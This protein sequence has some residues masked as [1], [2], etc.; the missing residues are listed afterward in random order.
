M[1]FQLPA[2][3]FPEAGRIVGM[4]DYEHALPFLTT[5]SLRF[6]YGN[7][8]TSSAHR[9]ERHIARL[10]AP[11]MIAAL[12]QAGFAALWIDRR[13]FADEAVPLIAA[14][15]AAGLRELPVPAALPLNV[16]RL[17][18]AESP[19]M[20]DLADPRLHDAWDDTAPPAHGRLYVL[21]GWY[22]PERDGARRWRWASRA[23]E[24][25]LWPAVAP[26]PACASA[27]TAPKSGTPNC[28]MA[29][30]RFTTS[31]YR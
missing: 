15:R 23:A 5:S 29:R 30:R 4:P 13:G 9:W 18:P 24:A 7:L 21:R 19:T 10:P 28:A 6:S 11:E 17:A 20:P 2:A 1:A 8:R 25:G 3:P 22:P 16:F 12:Q 14:L 31:S 27:S 26:A